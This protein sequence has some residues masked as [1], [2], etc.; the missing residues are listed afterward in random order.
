MAFNG[1][2]NVTQEVVDFVK[3]NEDYY[4]DS[5][6]KEEVL[7][8]LGLDYAES[9]FARIRNG[10]Y[11]KKFGYDQ[12]RQQPSS[13]P[14]NSP[15][16][17]QFN[18]Q[19]PQQNPP[20]QNNFSQPTNPWKNLQYSSGDWPPKMMEKLPQ[21]G[22][23]LLFA[24]LGFHLVGIERWIPL[25]NSL[26]LVCCNLSIILIIAGGVFSKERI[27]LIGGGLVFF[28]FSLK[29]AVLYMEEDLMQ[30]ITLAVIFLLFALGLW[31]KS[32]K[33]I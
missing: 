27:S 6:L 11:D 22:M 4:T 19:K 8:Q 16:Q 1:R 31:I 23:L 20:R 9:T 13:P 18:Q 33:R 24:F 25:F 5:E 10:A 7:S 28:A 15:K 17:T 30:H 26:Y 14:K 32:L 2:N 29:C 12:C 21:V 3:E